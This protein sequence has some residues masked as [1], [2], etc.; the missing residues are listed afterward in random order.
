[1]NHLGNEMG[2]PWNPRLVCDSLEG[3]G[4]ILDDL[5]NRLIGLTFGEPIAN[6]L[7]MCQWVED[8]FFTDLPIAS[9]NPEPRPHNRSF[10]LE[11][12]GAIDCVHA[13]GQRRV[14][15]CWTFLLL[16]VVWWLDDVLGGG[17]KEKEV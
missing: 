8:Y 4:G 14:G 16:D 2:C 10:W 12:W 3:L 11:E 13:G 15:A 7:E 17:R 9:R 1:M 6:V 5:L